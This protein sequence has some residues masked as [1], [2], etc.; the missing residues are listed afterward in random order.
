MSTKSLFALLPLMCVLAACGR[1]DNGETAPPRATI[2]RSRTSVE[3]PAA[4]QPQP[5]QAHASAPTPAPEALTDAAIT[6]RI[7][8]ALRA[9][10]AMSGA[11]VS[12]NTDKGVVVLSGT[13]KSHEQTGVASAHA[14]RQDGVMR[15]DNHLRPEYS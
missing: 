15:V 14:Q 3:A 5:K 2:E 9:D 13:V 6:S 8:S 4:E 10:P 11:D 1:V 7:S 12:I